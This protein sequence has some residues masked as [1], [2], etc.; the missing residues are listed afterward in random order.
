[1]ISQTTDRPERKDKR[2]HVDDDGS[3]CA[4]IKVMLEGE[5]VRLV[6]YSVGGLYFLSKKRY[7]AGD[8]I[9]VSMDIKNSK[10]MD[11]SGTVV[12]VRI[13]EGSWGIAIKFSERLETA[14]F[15]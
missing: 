14:I 9:N 7:Y 10:K 4:Q 5:M 15:S 3:T 12:Q 8:V 1:M 2:F 11:L 6:N 13:E